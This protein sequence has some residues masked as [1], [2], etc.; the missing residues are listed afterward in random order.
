MP[1]PPEYVKKHP[2][3]C[4]AG[5]IECAQGASLGLK[6]CPACDHP[7]RWLPGKPYTA[8]EMDQMHAVEN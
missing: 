5:Y 6:C 8:D 7:T 1:G 4:G 2:C 3:V